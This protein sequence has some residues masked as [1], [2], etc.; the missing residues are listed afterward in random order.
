M[1]ERPIDERVVSFGI[2]AIQNGVV[3]SSVE[4][5]TCVTPLQ[6]AHDLKTMFDGTLEKLN[7]RKADGYPIPGSIETRIDICFFKGAVGKSSRLSEPWYMAYDGQG[8][9]CLRDK[10]TDAPVFD[11]GGTPVGGNILDDVTV[12]L[13]SKPS[14]HAIDAI[15]LVDENGVLATYNRGPGIWTRT[16]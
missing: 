2:Q 7:S 15:A 3:V 9:Y 14:A 16:R 8:G 5:K 4:V 13:N 6:R 1:Q 11:V 12:Y 10:A